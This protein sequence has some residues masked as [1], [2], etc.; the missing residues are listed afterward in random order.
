MVFNC[1]L[2]CFV[3]FC[4]DFRIFSFALLF[5]LFVYLFV[6]LFVCFCWW[7]CWCCLGLLMGRQT[8]KRCLGIRKRDMGDS[9][10][11][12]WSRPGQARSGQARQ[13]DSASLC[14]TG[15]RVCLIRNIPG[16]RVGWISILSMLLTY[17][18]TAVLIITTKTHL[19]NKIERF[20]IIKYNI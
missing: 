10:V 16:A 7:W 1:F 3:L 2:F 14:F 20:I 4:F 5:A 9:G 11:R 12:D 17:Y 19:I 6:C 8:C 18:I 15:S 13:R